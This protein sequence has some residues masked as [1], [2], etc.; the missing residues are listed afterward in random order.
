MGDI[1][2]TTTPGVPKTAASKVD[3]PDAIIATS[4]ISK[5]CCGLFFSSFTHLGVLSSKLL[6]CSDFAHPTNT[7]N[8]GIFNFINFADFINIEKCLLNSCSRLP[9]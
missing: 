4:A 6:I 5:A 2:Y 9:G 1:L 8:S 3:V 7:C